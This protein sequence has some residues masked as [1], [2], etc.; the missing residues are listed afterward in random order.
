MWLLSSSS[1]RR[2]LDVV[3]GT[4][5]F[6][7][8]GPHYSRAHT[9]Q[10]DIHWCRSGNRSCDGNV[11]APYGACVRQRTPRAAGS[12]GQSWTA[13]TNRYSR[14]LCLAQHAVSESWCWPII[15][16]DP[17]SGPTETYEE[18]ERRYGELPTEQLRTEIDVKRV[19][20]TNPGFCYMMAGWMRGEM[21]TRQAVL[22]GTSRCGAVR[23]TEGGRI[24]HPTAWRGWHGRRG[25]QE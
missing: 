19:R 5:P 11:V 2:A 23:F 25:I 9:R 13:R 7:G 8:M 16:L 6:D 17:V 3:D 12:G 4:G 18:W 22:V 21:K 1:D 20:S 10:Q 24:K 14:T 15:G